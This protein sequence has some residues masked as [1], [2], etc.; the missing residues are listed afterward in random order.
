MKVLLHQRFFRLLSEYLQHKVPTSELSEAIEELTTLFSIIRQL[1]YDFD[2]LVFE[3]HQFHRYQ[4]ETSGVCPVRRI[5]LFRTAPFYVDP[6][7][8]EE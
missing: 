3:F 4:C 7:K 1:I 5:C 6:N 2:N 8:L